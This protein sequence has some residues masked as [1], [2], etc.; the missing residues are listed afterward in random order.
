V[1]HDDRTDEAAAAMRRQERRY[2]AMFNLTPNDG[3]NTRQ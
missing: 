3:N 2:L 1:G